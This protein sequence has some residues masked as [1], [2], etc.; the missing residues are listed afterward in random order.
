MKTFIEQCSEIRKTIELNSVEEVGRKLCSER[1]CFPV[2]DIYSKLPMEKVD[3]T[4][5]EIKKYI[6][7]INK[8]FTNTELYQHFNAKS[9]KDKSRIYNTVYNLKRRGNV[10]IIGGKTGDKIFAV[11][12]YNVPIFT[13]VAIPKEKN[14]KKEAVLMMLKKMSKEQLIQFCFELMIK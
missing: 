10:K 5:T 7:D 6:N 2:C 11:N 14:I 4:H 1:P 12:N 13:N 9:E 8:P 3:F